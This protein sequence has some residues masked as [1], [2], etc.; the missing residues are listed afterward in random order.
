MKHLLF[1]FVTISLVASSCKKEEDN[2]QFPDW[3]QQKIEE[4]IINQSF[5]EICEVTVTSY[6]GKKYYDLYCAHWSCMRCHF[7]DE[8]GNAPEW[9]QEEWEAYEGEKKI[10]VVLPACRK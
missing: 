8:E 1:L 10:I 9:G 5:C 4:V 7:Y 3:L 6:N 2:E